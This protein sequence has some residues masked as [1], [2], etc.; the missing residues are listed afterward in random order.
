M[1]VSVENQKRLYVLVK[2]KT[3]VGQFAGQEGGLAPARADGAT[4]WY[5]FNVTSLISKSLLSEIL[6]GLSGGA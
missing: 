2:I 1:R 6:S 5:Y 4:G 3:G